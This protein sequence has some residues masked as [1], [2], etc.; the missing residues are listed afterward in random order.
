LP[1]QASPTRG[2]QGTDGV[3]SGFGGD[4][5]STERTRRPAH[6]TPLG[7]GQDCDFNF[8]RFRF[9]VRK[10]ARQEVRVLNKLLVQ[11]AEDL[12][13]YREDLTWVKPFVDKYSRY[14]IETLKQDFGTQKS[15]LLLAR[16]RVVECDNTRISVQS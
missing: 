8:T 15:A 10:I 5:G 7:L 14:R 4:K 3:R 9:R 16:Q 11:C 13:M 6:T 2:S 1:P 12:V